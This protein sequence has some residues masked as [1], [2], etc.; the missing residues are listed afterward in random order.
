MAY[1]TYS[2]GVNTGAFNQQISILTG[3]TLKFFTS[4]PYN[5]R[6]AVQ[7]E[8]LKN[9]EL[10]IKGSFLDGKANLTADVYYDKWTNQL[11]S[12]SYTIPPN[13][14]VPLN[15]DGSSPDL[16]GWV[17]NT[18]S[19]TAKGLEVSGNIVPV[20]HVI[21]NVAGAIND[22]KYDSFYCLPCATYPG[23]VNA[24]G[25]AL[26]NS[27]KYSSTVGA[28]YS[29]VLTVWNAK[30]WYVRTD[31]IYRAG[32]YLES[33]NTSRT[34]STELVNLRGGVNWQNLRAELFVTNL[35]NN[36]AY[37]SGFPDDNFTTFQA[38]T[39]VMLGLPQL[40]TYGARVRYSF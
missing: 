17:D 31:F 2:E 16:V 33:L 39:A 7:P 34:P 32:V 27:P 18:G 40:V 28:Q 8:K 4:P 22:T 35:F 20:E 9:Y 23:P 10:G 1:A 38:Q 14:T 5:A 21:L 25:N 26:P 3:E 24:A 12:R 19:S 37:T 29:N 36:K 6:V 15:P 11:I 13:S 30:D